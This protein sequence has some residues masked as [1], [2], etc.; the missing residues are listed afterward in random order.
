MK[1]K[2]K[3]HGYPEIKKEPVKS[4]MDFLYYQDILTDGAYQIVHIYITDLEKEISL[5]IDRVS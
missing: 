2:K 3:Y 1:K 5:R 4:I